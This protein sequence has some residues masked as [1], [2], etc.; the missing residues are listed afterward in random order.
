MTIPYKKSVIP[1]CD[2]LDTTAL[3]IGSVN[4]IVNDSEGKL[5]GYNTD[6]FGF[7]AMCKC[8]NIDFK[9]KKVL[10]LGSGGTS[11]TV[12]AVATDMGASEI[13]VV[14]RTEEK[15]TAMWIDIWT[16]M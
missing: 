16:A 2:S 1:Y 8:S 13:I 11:A 7:L 14:S 4:T 5:R 3:R 10:I 9:G 15:T 6:Y 12:H